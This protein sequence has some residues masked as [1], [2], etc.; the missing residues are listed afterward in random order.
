VIE[1][2]QCRNFHDQAR[3]SNPPSPNQVKKNSPKFPF[4]RLKPDENIQPSSPLDSHDSTLTLYSLLGENK[5]SKQT[6]SDGAETDLPSREIALLKGHKDEVSHLT[7][8]NI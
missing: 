2:L 4:K 5:D 7:H 8:L 1:A 6:R 3:G